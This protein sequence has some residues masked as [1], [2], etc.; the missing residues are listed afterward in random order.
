MSFGI[1]IVIVFL[2]GGL[3]FIIGLAVGQGDIKDQVAKVCASHGGTYIKVKKGYETY[4]LKVTKETPEEK[5]I[6]AGESCIEWGK[7]WD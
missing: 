4:Y 7:L 2:V 1:Y 3:S 6:V 5:T